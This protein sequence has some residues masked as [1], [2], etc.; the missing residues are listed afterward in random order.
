Y[1]GQLQADQTLR[2]TDRLNGGPSPI[3]TGTVQDSN[4]PV[5]VPC[6]ATA[7]SGGSTC[8][9]VTTANSLVPGL[10]AAGRRTIWELGQVKVYDGGP[11]GIAS[12]QP[13]TLFAVEGLFVP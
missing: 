13:N 3:E 4:F 9:I 10:L 1:T 8:S 11:D 7:G 2:I 6:A 5:T 12:T